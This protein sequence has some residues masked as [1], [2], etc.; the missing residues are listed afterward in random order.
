ML[1]STV[2]GYCSV[3]P[4]GRRRVSEA[5]TAIYKTVVHHLVEFFGD[6]DVTE[7]DVA[8]LED[9]QA[10][11]ESRSESNV[12]TDNTYKRTA[13]SL[14]RYMAKRKVAV[15][16][17]SGVFKF[18]K[19]I[20]GVKSI[21][22]KNAHRMLAFSG[23][24][25][26]AIILLA[27]ESACRRGG[28]ATMKKSKTKIWW[29]EEMGEYCLAA[30]VVEKGDK[31][32]WIFGYNDSALAMML[33]LKIRNGFMKSMDY[34]D[35]DHVFV[36]LRDGSP[37]AP[38]AMSANNSRIKQKANIPASEPCNLHAHRHFRAKELLKRLSLDEVSDILGHE[39][40]STTAIYTE[41]SELEL[42]EAFFRTRRNKR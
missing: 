7:I 17:V 38:P 34:E 25:E 27:N 11:L 21:S 28:L 16:D 18:R 13:R 35:H 1:L 8:D 6:A 10:W 32:R 2:A 33:W 5:T 40:I 15:C 20:K 26:T 36:N 22:V 29:D 3:D 37:L 14:W 4:D 23:I 9:W 39:D 19:E 31:P 30:E 42:A 41:R 24:R 12:V